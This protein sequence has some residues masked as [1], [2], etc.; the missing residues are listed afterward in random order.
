MTKQTEKTNYTYILKCADGTFYC[1]WTN[2]LEKRLA[3]HNAG[4]ASKYTAPR[5]PVEL[6]YTE[7]FKTKQEAM[8]REYHIKQLTRQQKIDLI[9]HGKS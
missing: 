6:I 9:D 7:Q 1:G 4:T 2:N 5:R 3:A 8:S